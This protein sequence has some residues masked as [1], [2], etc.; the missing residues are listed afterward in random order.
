MSGFPP[1]TSLARRPNGMP[2]MT[3]NILISV[4]ICLACLALVAF[5]SHLDKLVG[6]PTY[7]TLSNALA[8]GG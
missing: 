3:R 4:G 7:P 6:L 2:P 5:F 8:T 1:F